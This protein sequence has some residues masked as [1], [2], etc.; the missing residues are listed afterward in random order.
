[1]LVLPNQLSEENNK[2]LG[3]GYDPEGDKLHLMA[4]VN[5]SR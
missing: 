1:M 3:L 5:F 4:A 2:A